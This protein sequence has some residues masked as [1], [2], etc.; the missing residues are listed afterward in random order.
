MRKFVW[1]FIGIFLV[2]APKT[3]ADGVGFP[4]PVNS[5]VSDNG[6]G[7]GSGDSLLE[8][9]VAFLRYSIQL[10]RD[11][12][13]LDS[14]LVQFQAYCRKMIQEARHCEDAARRYY[15]SML[16][17][18]RYDALKITLYGERINIISHEFDRMRD[19]FVR[20]CER[21]KENMLR[22][23]SLA[24]EQTELLPDFKDDE[25]R[26]LIQENI[27]YIEHFRSVFSQ[28]E[29]AEA[30]VLDEIA[31][32]AGVLKEIRQDSDERQSQVI[33]S[34]FF[35]NESNFLETVPN[36]RIH[37]RY[38]LEDA[39]NNLTVQ[40]LLLKAVTWKFFV[41]S[42]LCLTALLLAWAF[43]Y[44]GFLKGILEHKLPDVFARRNQ[45][46]FSILMISFWLSI[47]L[48]TTSNNGSDLNILRQL[49]IGFLLF[50]TMKLAIVL[51]M[52]KE[53]QKNVHSL[54][55]IVEGCYFIC[56]L[57]SVNVISYKPLIVLSTV[58]A[59]LAFCLVAWRICRG[60]FL[61]PERIF[62][63]CTL[64]N[65]LA[66]AVLGFLGFAYV[67]LT[68]MLSWFVLVALM[69][70]LLGVSHFARE[71]GEVD[72]RH[73]VFY[74]IFH[75]L[76]LPLGWIGLVIYM[77]QWL[78]F[79]FHV[80]QKLNDVLDMEIVRQ[81]VVR[82]DIRSL[83][84]GL[85][86]GVLLYFALSSIK[87]LLRTYFSDYMEFGILPSII[88]LGNYLA[89]MIY[90][91]LLLLWLNVDYSGVLV[92]LGGMS[93]GLGFGLKEMVENFL[94]GLT[95][96][97]GQ[98]VRPGDIVENC[99]TGVIGRIRQIS[100]R[101]TTVETFD[102]AMMT[103][104]NALV[105]GKEFKNWTSN[106]TMRRS[107]V[108]ISVAYGSDLQR[109]V[110]VIREVLRK[111]SGVFN[112]PEPEILLSVFN[113]SSVDFEVRFWSNVLRAAALRSE[114]QRGVYDAFAANGIEMPY[115]QLD[116]H[117]P[118]AGRGAGVT[119]T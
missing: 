33:S 15:Y 9:K 68:L 71:L 24:R 14:G 104:P 43:F 26:H 115:P 65:Y 67:S 87:L 41:R 6:S 42:G 114:V 36:A 109:A 62:A 99:D 102:G 19:T 76:L 103:Y 57:L 51:R 84:L 3:D 46:R 25:T 27:N 60:N 96:L 88:I 39:W 66:A 111:T 106:N 72:S 37:I 112:R 85:L 78:S 69:Q 52:G 107:S 55:R 12:E 11:I 70:G 75:K 35:N 77:V 101:A 7:D 89:W 91:V 110:E 18:D 63:V 54:Y 1:I 38:W 79:T 4:V 86:A 16:Q 47:L 58:I 31:A 94:A 23:D 117:F 113:A 20:T 40:V 32:V 28:W 2:C 10:K 119:D 59:F 17:N 95:L 34:I 49:S 81:N 74:R 56:L 108:V 29:D 90:V 83:M 100:V 44:R 64:V 118:D 98:Q 116:V 30:G 80:E 45:F 61:L 48:G 93:M 21:V 5:A 82:F 50:F 105:I 73:Q 22:Y 53:M 92:V 97:L 13:L 8:W